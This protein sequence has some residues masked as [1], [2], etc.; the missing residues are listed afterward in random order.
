MSKK[1]ANNSNNVKSNKAKT[2][3]EKPKVLVILGSTSSGKTALAVQLA[4]IF[5]GEIISADSRQ[6][7]RGLD[8]GTGKDLAEYKFDG[9]NIK[10]HLIDVVEPKDNFDLAQYQA[11]ARIA[12]V[13]VLR[14]QKLPI[15]VGGSGLYLQAVI[16]NFK[17]AVTSPDLFARTKLEKLAAPQLLARLAKIKPDFAARLNNSDS[18]NPRRLVRYLEIAQ[19]G[20]AID[21]RQ[22]SPYDFLVLGLNASDQLL[23]SKINYRLL[24]MLEKEGLIKEVHDLHQNGLSWERLESYG[25]E[26]RFVA[27]HLQGQLSYAEMIEKLGIA[28]YR[29]SKRQKTW[30][31]RWAK[32]GRKIVWLKN[33]SKAN[34]EIVGWLAK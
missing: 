6:V 4:A 23:R 17:L 15:I 28:I 11:L 16:D 19:A 1:V 9:Q 8:I 31:K 20:G 3:E 18:H 12:I 10:Y 32:Q 30:F 14:R 34:R 26:Y 24:V 25:L 13:D 2:L 33:L 29:F 5:N 27:Q 21:L 22:E 7:Y